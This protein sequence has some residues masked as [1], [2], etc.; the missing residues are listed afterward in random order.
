MDLDP[1]RLAP[2]PALPGLF[3]GGQ[4]ALQQIEELQVT[5]VLV[6]QRTA[7]VLQGG[8]SMAPQQAA[9]AQ[10]Q[11]MPVPVHT[12]RSAACPAGLHAHAVS[13]QL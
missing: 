6:S 12:H 7:A 2:P 10:G 9:R 11:A 8:R 4:A 13:D 5:H 3:I 1:A